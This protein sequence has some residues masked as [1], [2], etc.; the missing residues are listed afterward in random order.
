M[1]ASWWVLVAVC[2][3]ELRPEEPDSIAETF[4]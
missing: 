3:R 1:E 4:A 2:Y